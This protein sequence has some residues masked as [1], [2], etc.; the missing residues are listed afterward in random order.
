MREPLV[1]PGAKDIRASQRQVGQVIDQDEVGMSDER[2]EFRGKLV[3]KESAN[4]NELGRP[5]GEIVE[6]MGFA[7]ARRSDE[8]DGGKGRTMPLDRSSETA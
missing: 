5:A 7:A 2:V 6:Q 8:E 4:G 1:P 3:G